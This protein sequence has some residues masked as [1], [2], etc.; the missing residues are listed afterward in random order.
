MFHNPFG[1]LAFSAVA[2]V[3]ALH[4]FRR[5]FRAHVVGALFLWERRDESV[6]TGRTR[7]TLHASPSFWCEVLAA[8]L[9]ALVISSPRGC[10]GSARHLVVVLDSSASMSAVDG[11]T[12]E[13]AAARASERLR[14]RL[15]ELSARGR[16][17]LVRS[18]R[19]PTLLAGP[20]ARVPDALRAL[21][22]WEPGAGR[23][24][25]EPALVLAAQLAGADD[26]WLLTD[27][28]ALRERFSDV[29]V[30]AVG[31]PA[32]N[33]AIARAARVREHEGAVVR[34]RVFASVQSFAATPRTV[35][36]RWRRE[37]GESESFSLD[38]D[39][40]GIGHLGF[41]LPEGAGW[42]ELALEEDALALDN[43]VRLLPAPV[44]ELRLYSELSGALARRLGLRG[45]ADAEE[46]IARWR[47]LVGDSRRAASAAE[48]H[49]VL[50]N[51]EVP[52]TWTVLLSPP[53]PDRVDSS[54]PFLLEKD[55]PLLFGATLEGLV[56]SYDPAFEAPGVGLAWAGKAPLIV[57]APVA[58]DRRTVYLNVDSGRST[59]WRSPDWPIL[60]TNLAE[61]RRATL[62]GPRA[63]N[64]VLGE[65]FSFRRP[66][67]GR[68]TWRGP[69]G[70]GEV[71]F[72]DP[73]VVEGLDRPGEYTLL[74]DEEEVARFAVHFSD[75][76]ESDL[77]ATGS[78][79]LDDVP[80]DA[81]IRAE[82]SL[83]QFGLLCVVL[84]LVLLDWW[85]LVRGRPA[86]VRGNGR[87][88]GG[89]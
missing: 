76:A 89:A 83:L 23:H 57:D 55:H 33:A 69:A 87:E 30:T 7:E 53:G 51:R 36:G 28:P 38:L 2:A 19:P 34:D 81:R 63:T 66:E 61:E 15:A 56:W 62:P 74:R 85:L 10:G 26:V 14:A 50:S 43:T 41:D 52:E 88:A 18:G 75:P 80:S 24:D 31:R 59:L 46:S 49:L 54:G 37:S 5:R 20:A 68:Y 71:A 6:R 1:L 60:L 78:A 42:V 58:A 11:A 25:L 21:A 65:P 77:R 12:G 67:P 8:A 4:L 3:V 9:L 79:G 72:A 70:A 32:A 86:P 40:G 13:S 27:R 44:R 39:P 73:L 64:L 16:V 82:L 48:A 47:A 35:R 29:R 45:A 22:S 84:A 17:T